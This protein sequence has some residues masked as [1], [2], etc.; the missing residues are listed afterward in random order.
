MSLTVVLVQMAPDF[1]HSAMFSLYL[2]T[3]NKLICRVTI[4]H[5]HH[6]L[7][8]VLALSN[9][10]KDDAFSSEHMSGSKA[11]ARTNAR[12]SKAKPAQ[13]TSVDEVSGGGEGGLGRGVGRVDWEEGEGRVDWEEGEGR[14]DWEE[15]WGRMDWE[16]GWERV[17][18]EEGVGESGFGRGELGRRVGLERRMTCVQYAFR[19]RSKQRKE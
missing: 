13:H 15:G 9:A 11:S 17:D 4:D 16:V 7:Y 5:P 12:L 10:S 1:C 2:C 18:G 6:C 3:P 19:I 14:V 8:V